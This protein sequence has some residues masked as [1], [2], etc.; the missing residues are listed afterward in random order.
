VFVASLSECFSFLRVEFGT[1]RL[2]SKSIFALSA[3]LYFIFLY[4]CI[5]EQS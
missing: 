4:S 3:T 5:S 1:A 2:E